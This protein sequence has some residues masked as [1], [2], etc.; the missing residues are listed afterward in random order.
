M[1]EPRRCW[2]F[3]E[4]WSEW[5]DWLSGGLHGRTRWRLPV[6]MLG[7]LF[8]LGRRSVTTWLRAAGVRDDFANYYYFLSSVGR[9]PRSVSTKLILLVLQAVPLPERVLSV[10]DDSPTK[11]YGPLVEPADIHHN[12]TPS[13][14]DQT[15]LCGHVWVTLS[16]AVRHPLWGAIGLPLR[17]MLYVRQKT[18]PSNPQRSGLEV[19]NQA[20]TGSTLDEADCSHPPASGKNTVGRGG[21]R[22]HQSLRCEPALAAGVVIVGRLHKDAALHDLPP[23]RR[24]RRRPRKY[25]KSKFSL[26]KRGGHESGWCE[27]E[28]VLFG[29]TAT[30]CYK[31]F[32]ATYRPAGGVIRVVSIKE[33]H[34]CFTLFCTNP[35]A[36]AVEIL[37]AFADRASIEQDFHDIKE[38]W[39]AGQQRARNI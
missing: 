35:N 37:E 36:T 2:K 14:A 30:K 4:E 16:L 19:R 23:K 13:P 15:Q 7:I 25:G 12:P 17:A 27:A 24:G 21:W 11:R 6:L 22:V 29:K 31:T 39:S 34:A 1:V 28:C 32:L 38:V 18:I 20:R 33:E 8:A 3:P 26:A 5:S 10:I 9:K